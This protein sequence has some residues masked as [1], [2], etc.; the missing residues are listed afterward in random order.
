[1]KQVKNKET[2]KKNE[3]EKQEDE[4]HTNATLSFP[5]NVI[6]VF[7]GRENDEEEI[8]AFLMSTSLRHPVFPHQLVFRTSKAVEPTISLK[9]VTYVLEL[10]SAD[11]KKNSL[12]TSTLMKNLRVCKKFESY[13]EEQ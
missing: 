3:N 2:S 8:W 1:M 6:F 13:N 11:I 12:Q 9:S 10:R 4:E 7:E 5:N